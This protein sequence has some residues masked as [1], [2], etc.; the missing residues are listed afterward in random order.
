[1][2]GRGLTE[3]ASVPKLHL[4]IWIER[5]QIHIAVRQRVEMDRA[6]ERLIRLDQQNRLRKSVVVETLAEM[7][8]RLDREDLERVEIK[9]ERAQAERLHDLHEIGGEDQHIVA[10]EFDHDPELAI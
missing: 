4:A 7:H 6:Q 8:P 5:P 3:Q 2:R 9:A 1:M 10:A